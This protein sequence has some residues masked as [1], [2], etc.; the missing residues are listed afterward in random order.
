[1]KTT[2]TQLNFTLPGP[3]LASMP[4]ARCAWCLVETGQPLGNGSHGICAAHKARELAAWRARKA[5]G[6]Q[7]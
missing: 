1:M 6:R 4:P 2:C 7:P 3:G 5:Q